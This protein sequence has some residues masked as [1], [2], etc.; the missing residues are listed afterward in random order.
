MVFSRKESEDYYRN[1]PRKRIGAGVLLLN[2][3]GELLIVKPTYKNHWS[4]PGG[5]VDENESPREAVIRETKEETGLKLSRCRLLSVDYKSA[6]G[7]KGDGLQFVFYGG[8]LSPSQIKHI[9]LPAAELSE[10]RFLPVKEAC[11]LV[12]SK[13]GRRILKSLGGALK[14][15]K[16]LYLE[17]QKES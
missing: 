16:I 2:R 9:K 6:D 8:T 10:Y 17:D 12:S 15:G 1:L 13:L 7:F 5:V 14:R 4:V 11:R 3:R